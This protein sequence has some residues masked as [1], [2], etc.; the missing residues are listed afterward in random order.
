MQIFDDDVK[1]R[2]REKREI[3]KNFFFPAK[4]HKK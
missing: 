1:E 3:K 4:E 2:E